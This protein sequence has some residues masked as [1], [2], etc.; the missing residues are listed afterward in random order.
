MRSRRIGLFGLLGTGNLGNDG[1]LAAV[2]DHLRAAHPDATLHAFCGGPDEVTERFGLP[3]TRMNWYRG[4]YRTANTIRSVFLKGLGKIIDAVRTAVWV[5]RQDVVIVP[6]MGVLES[7]LPV[8]PWG[9]PYSLMLTCL[10]GRLLGTPVALLSVGA[11]VVEN[12]VGRMVVVR[13]AKAAGYRSFRDALSRDAMRAMGVDTDGD[14]IYPDLVFGATAPPSVASTGIVGVGV[15][16]YR[17]ENRD[18]SRAHEVRARYVADLTTFVRWLVAGDRRVR[19]FIGDRSDLVVAV[20]ITAEV[21]SPLV[22]TAKVTDLD[23]LMGAM[24][25]V[26]TVVATRYHNV[27]CALKLGIPTVSIGYA[28]KND[29]LMASMGLGEFCQAAR[30]IDV[31]LL[32]KQFTELERRHDELRAT[33]AARGLHAA[34][35]VERQFAELSEFIRQAPPRDTRVGQGVG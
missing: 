12:G 11:T 21:G 7:V 32:I 20:E 14:E 2:L 4:E 34:G 16:A 10:S 1:S 19:L 27:V 15:M 8:R 24:A 29:A 35:L 23:E 28:P 26:D 25:E 22:E 31:G 33:V 13:A 18:R 3:A 30:S 9:F 17:G 6:G 5:R